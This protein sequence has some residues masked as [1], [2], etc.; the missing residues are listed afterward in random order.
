MTE[1]K[2]PERAFPLQNYELER[3]DFYRFE[4][5]KSQPLILFGLRGPGGMNCLWPVIEVLKKENYPIDLLIDSAAKRILGTKNSDFI[6]QPS[7][8]PLKRI[9]ETKP[10]VAITEFSADEGTALAVTW[11]E[12]SFGVPTV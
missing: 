4:G 8:S 5:D 1:Q 2:L 12:E 3:T 7:E 6:K 9:M 11:S 10:A